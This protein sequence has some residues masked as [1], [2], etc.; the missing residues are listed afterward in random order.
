MLAALGLSFATAGRAA[1]Q[2]DTLQ[3]REIAVPPIAAAA[4]GAG[5]GEP[6]V[7][8]ETRQG[9]VSVWLLRAADTVFVAAHIPDRTP[10]W[11][12]AFVVCLDPAGAGEVAPGHD[13]FEWSLRRSLDSS[14][15]YRGRDGRWQPPLND[16]DWRIGTNHAG[17]GWEAG[18]AERG[19]GWT[20]VL[21]LDP[22][23]FAGASGRGP[24]MAFQVHDDD[25]D[26][27]YAW[28]RA[29]RGDADGSAR[30]LDARPADWVPVR[31]D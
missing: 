21:R 31:H 26:A 20:V 10:S 17:G 18:A 4:P 14:V 1:G 11:S 22:A 7:A 30:T 12:D 23:W 16:P 13:D 5:W 24:R 6:Q 2:G 29:A 19:P 28:P 25:P 9:L 8:I 27:W 15:V 3:V